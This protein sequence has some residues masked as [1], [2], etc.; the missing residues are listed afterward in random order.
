MAVKEVDALHNVAHDLPNGRKVAVDTVFGHTKY[1]LLSPV[2][3]FIYI[4]RLIVGESG[5]LAGGADQPT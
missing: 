1:E 5:D 2:N 4:L 3:N